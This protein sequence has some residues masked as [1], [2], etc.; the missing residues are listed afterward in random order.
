MDAEGSLREPFV[1]VRANKPRSV[2]C[3]LV[4]VRAARGGI[5]SSRLANIASGPNNRLAS[6]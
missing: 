5:T 2:V 1:N 6:P 3:K 4:R